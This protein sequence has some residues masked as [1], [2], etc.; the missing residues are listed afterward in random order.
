MWLRQFEPYVRFYSGQL[1]QTSQ[2][3]RNKIFWILEKTYRI[4]R[5]VRFEVRWAGHTTEE[6]EPYAFNFS[7]NDEVNSQFCF[8]KKERNRY[9]LRRVIG[10]IECM[11]FSI[12]LSTLSRLLTAFFVQLTA[13][14]ADD[15]NRSY[16]RYHTSET[17]YDGIFH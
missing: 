15:S 9:C 12:I 6:K 4:Y 13:E 7:Y 16:L 3:F 11:F 8:L 14:E 17:T 5:A 10:K 2:T 1:Q